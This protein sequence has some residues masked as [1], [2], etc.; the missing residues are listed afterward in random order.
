MQQIMIQKLG[1]NVFI[2][3]QIHPK[4]RITYYKSYY[5]FFPRLEKNIKCIEKEHSIVKR[6][7]ALH[8]MYRDCQKR[9]LELNSLNIH[10]AISG[11][12]SEREFLLVLKKRYA[13]EKTE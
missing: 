3:N 9:E 5:I 2:I 13:G 8:P 6:W 7:S 12:K 1:S 4:F 10:D 11:R